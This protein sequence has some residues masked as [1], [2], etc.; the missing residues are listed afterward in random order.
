MQTITSAHSF[1]ER[2]QRHKDGSVLLS[3]ADDR[4]CKLNCVGALTWMILEE[5][6]TGLR[7]DDVV[8]EL[9][10]QFA[11]INAEGELRY[12]VSHEQLHDDTAQFL[13]KISAMNLLRIETDPRGQHFYH[14]S[15]GVSGTTSSTVN[16]A[17]EQEATTQTG[18]VPGDIRLSKLE[19]FAAFVGLLCFDLLLKSRGFQ[20]LIE[21]VEH[22]PT[23]NPRTTDPEVCRR[24][25]A[26]VDRAQMYYPKKATCL[27]HSAVVTCLLRQRGVPAEMILAA[28]EFPPRGHAWVEVEGRV[29]ND[30]QVVKKSHRVLKRV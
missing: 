6:P 3:I 21:R 20:A 7:V 4:V 29:V 24:V 17:D 15:E 26:M 12:E 10:D 8:R 28:Q 16:V 30:S 9:S 1:T 25:R 22:W 13:K 27:Q 14:I 18:P 2:A 5:N 23:K 19:T 11:A